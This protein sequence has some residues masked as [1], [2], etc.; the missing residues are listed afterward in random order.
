[1]ITWFSAGSL[2]VRRA[3]LAVVLAGLGLGAVEARAEAPAQSAKSREMRELSEARL[4]AARAAAGA[5]KAVDARALYGQALA[6]WLAADAQVLAEQEAPRPSSVVSVANEQPAEEAPAAAPAPDAEAAR[7]QREA[8]ERAARERAEAARQQAQ[9]EAAQREAARREEEARRAAPPSPAT[10]VVATA[11]PVAAPSPPA[12]FAAGLRLVPQ[13][14]DPAG[15]EHVSAG[16]IFTWLTLA[17]PYGRGAALVNLEST[18][19]RPGRAD[20]ADRAAVAFYGLGLDWTVPFARHGTG[21]Y[22]GAEA[23][24]GVLQSSRMSTAGVA[25]DGVLMLTPHVGGAVAY[26]GVGVF[27]DAGWRFQL[28]ADTATSGQAK[29]G[30]LLLQ[31]GLRAELPRGAAGDGRDLGLGYTV[32]FYSPNGSRVWNR[33]GGLFGAD[34]GP[35]VGHELSLVTSFG[36]PRALHLDYGLALTYLGAG[37]DGGGTA[38]SMLGLGALVTWHAFPA[39]QL[40][41]PYVGGRLSAVYISSDDPTTFQYKSQVSPTA[42][43]MAGLDV[44]I[45]RRVAL[46]VGV[47]YDA[48]G[49]A[50]NVADA[51]LSGYAVE[52]GLTVRL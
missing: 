22:V 23:A 20:T 39:H 3:G 35:L 31:G 7:A 2:P 44:A 1:M 43:I 11:P 8:E 17:T 40:L 13:A 16:L 24:G 28:L 9:L 36:L 34:A 5:G 19:W 33:Y 26:R 10:V 30:G 6:A 4:A 18:R 49:N 21:L 47:A 50:N 37:Q 38:L 48:V 25:T 41:N 32:R 14:K 29:E 27:V 45:L 42:S 46:R 52:A 12:T 15:N 51:S